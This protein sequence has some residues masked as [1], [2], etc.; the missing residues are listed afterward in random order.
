[1][2]HLNAELLAG[3]VLGQ[4]DQ[5]SPEQLK[6]LTSCPQ[7]RAEV[8]ELRRI[9]ELSS[10]SAELAPGRVPAD[11]I[12]RSIE[13]EMAADNL[14][15]TVHPA[16]F[17]VPDGATPPALEEGAAASQSRPS[18]RRWAVLAAAAVGLILGVGGTVLVNV[19]RSDDVE[20]VSATP[21]SALPGET[22]RGNAELVRDHGTTR[23]RVSVDGSAPPQ[24]FREVWLINTDGKRMYSLGVL[25]GGGAGSYPVPTLLGSS[26]DGFTIVDVSI[27][28]YD[29]N[30]AHSLHS[31]V[32]GTLPL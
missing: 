5:L 24:E 21:L 4:A 20:I 14:S 18:T 3:H 9:V 32:R 23:L 13:A 25:P 1:M 29:G 22:G 12:W 27:E 2:V 30:A 15:D 17:K 19:V 8:E 26:L 28:P 7:C 11:A 10:G 6:H 16:G 31:Q